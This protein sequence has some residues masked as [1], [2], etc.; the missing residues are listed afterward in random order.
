MSDQDKNPMTNDE[1]RMTDSDEELIKRGDAKG[2]L[3]ARVRPGTT[4]WNRGW[5]A[6]LKESIAAIDALEPVALSPAQAQDKPDHEV[7]WE[8]VKA[9]ALLD[10]R[11]STFYDAA[12]KGTVTFLQRIPLP[13]DAVV[14][15]KLLDISIAMPRRSR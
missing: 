3:E 14:E 5:N 1:S 12:V 13:E 2:P 11:S 4:D 9:G 6:A 7:L 15:V 8:Q 10:I